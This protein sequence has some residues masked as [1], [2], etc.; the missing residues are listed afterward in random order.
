MKRKCRCLKDFATLCLARE[1]GPMSRYNLKKGSFG[2]VK[3]KLNGSV[4]LNAK[5]FIPMD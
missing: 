3:I 4:K 5:H 2:V 1:G